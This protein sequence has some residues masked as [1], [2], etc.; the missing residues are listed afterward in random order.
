MKICVI[1]DIHSSTLW[2][3][4]V[5]RERNGVDRFVFLG[6]YFDSKAEDITSDEQVDNFDDI[7]EFKEEFGN[8]DLLIGNHDLQYIGGARTNQFKLHT[9]MLVDDTLMDLVRNGTLQVCVAYDGYLFSHAGISSVWMKEHGLASITDIN[10]AFRYNPLLVDFV[11][12]PN[13]SLS[14]DNI[15]QSPL[16]IRPNSLCE[17]ALSNYH[18][19]VGHTRIEEVAV[20]PKGDKQLVFMDTELREYVVIDTVETVLTNKIIRKLWQKLQ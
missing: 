18:Q 20:I 3:D 1:S 4:I 13:G 9:Q 17:F 11:T 14:G 5:A 19:V 15:Y 16:W 6:D 10:N 8:V 7:L 2:K 12:K